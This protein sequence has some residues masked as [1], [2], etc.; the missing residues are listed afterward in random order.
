D[1]ESADRSGSPGTGLWAVT[2]DTQTNQE[3]SL[4][5]YQLDGVTG[6]EKQDSETPGVCGPINNVSVEEATLHMK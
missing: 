1:S 3:L 6:D 5:Q 2:T 4:K